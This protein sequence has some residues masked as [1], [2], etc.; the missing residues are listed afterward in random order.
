MQTYED[1]RVGN[2][3]APA[4]GV[5]LTA[6]D[7]VKACKI[8]GKILKRVPGVE[9]F[10]GWIRGKL[11]RKQ[12]LSKAA[13]ETLEDI[14]KTGRPPHRYKG[15]GRFKNEGRHGGQVLPRRDK[16]GNTNTYKEYDVAPHTK[17]VN[18]GT[19]RL[20]VGSDGRVY[21]T[22]DHFDTFVRVE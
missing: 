18:R 9:R 15:G 6:C 3:G 2:Y 22:T 19:E 17:G 14:R 12:A 5:F 16:M 11:I 20:V 7:V 13:K 21:Y 1:F 4:F 10:G 8:G